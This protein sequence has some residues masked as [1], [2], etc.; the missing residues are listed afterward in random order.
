MAEN[1]LKEN[2]K[3]TGINQLNQLYRPFMGMVRDT[4][5]DGEVRS[6][7]AGKDRRRW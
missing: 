3:A 7:S 1:K 4:A 5:D 2:R 6:S